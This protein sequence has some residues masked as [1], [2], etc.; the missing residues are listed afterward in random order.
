MNMPLINFD[1]KFAEFTSTWMQNHSY[2]TVDEM[3]E[4]LIA[5]GRMDAE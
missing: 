5:A 4:D 3:E 2:G 1:E